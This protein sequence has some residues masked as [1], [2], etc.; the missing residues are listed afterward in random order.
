MGADLLQG[1]KGSGKSKLAVM[2]MR[3]HLLAGRRVAT[4]LDLRLE[5]LLPSESRASAVRL[6]DKPSVFDLEAIGSGTRVGGDRYNED[7]DGLM[8]LDELATWMN[9]RTFADARR[10]GVLDW[11][12]H[13]RKHNWGTLLICQDINQIDKQVRTSHVDYVTRCL[14]LDR[15]RIPLVGGLL[16]ALFGK[17]FGYLPR[18]HVATRRLGVDPMG[19]KADSWLYTD[20]GVQE[21]YDTLQIFRD[22]YPHGSFSYLSP[23]HLVG[24]FQP[25]KVSGWKR[26]V[27]WFTSAPRRRPVA[28]KPKLPAVLLASQLPP[29]EAVKLAARYARSLDARGLSGRAINQS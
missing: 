28:V 1:K 15:V 3:E 25:E 24:R 12:V 26:L 2:L 13:S 29:G 27:Q 17:R 14:K 21:G 11:L 4:N 16:Q 18:G 8:V 23:W 19:L 10:Q 20:G 6:P 22:D 7:D 9:A 5:K